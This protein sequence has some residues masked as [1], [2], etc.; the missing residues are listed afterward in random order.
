MEFRSRVQGP[1]SIGN[2]F[3]LKKTPENR[4]EKHLSFHLT[5]LRKMDLFGTRI[6]FSIQ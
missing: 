1:D 2:I 3:G 4:L 6:P 5:I